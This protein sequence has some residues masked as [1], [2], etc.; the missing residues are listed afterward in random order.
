MADNNA[1]FKTD[2]KLGKFCIIIIPQ[3]KKTGQESI[4]IE[5]FLTGQKITYK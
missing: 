5:R 3:I 1:A 4:L 2:R